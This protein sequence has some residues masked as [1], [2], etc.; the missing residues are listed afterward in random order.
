MMP[1]SSTILL[2]LLSI[3]IFL[4]T[5]H[6]S[7]SLNSDGVLLLSFK[8]SILNDPLKVLEGWD[9]N[10]ATPCLWR[11]VSCNSSSNSN[12]SSF[13]LTALDGGWGGGGDT[14]RVVGVSLPG[15]QLLGSLPADLGL[16]NHLQIFNLSSNSL[17]GSIP[18]SLFSLPDLRVLD[19]SNNLITGELLDSIGGLRSLEVLDVSENALAGNIPR[20]LGTLRNLSFVSLKGNYFSGSIPGGFN[21]VRF[22]DLSSNLLNGSLPVDLG[23]E[24]IQRFNLSFN[25]ISGDIS[26]IFGNK[27]PENATLDFSYNNITGEIPD[28]NV[29]VSQEKDSFAGN[30]DLCG[31]PSGNPCAIPSSP[32]SLPTATTSQPI[33]PPAFAAIPKSFATS[34]DGGPNQENP[35]P[36]K[37]HG[38]RPRIIAAIVVGDLTGIAI[39]AMVFLYACKRKNNSDDDDDTIIN[40]VKTLNNRS[41]ASAAGFRRDDIHK[42]SSTSRSSSSSSESKG[43][44]KWSCLRKVKNDDNNNDDDDDDTES[45]SECRSDDDRKSEQRQ[46]Q[47]GKLVTVDGGE[48]ELELETLLKA[49]AYI[50]GA[51]G[52]SITYKA[53]LEDGTVLAV[54]RVGESN[55]V[56]KMKD[57]EGHV[58]AVAKFVHPNLVK[59]RGFYWG[60]DEKLVIYEYVSN[61]SLAN[62]RYR[63]TGSSPCHIP[64]SV[65]LR[66]AK[67]IA[68]GLNYIHEKKNVHGNLKPNNVL[69]DADMEPKISDFGL[70]RLSMGKFSF[71]PGGSTRHF[72]SKRSTASRESFQ[73]YSVGA[74]P[75]PSGS[76]IGSVSPYHPPESLRSLKPNSKWDVY[77]FGVMLL[78]LLTGKVVIS[79]EYGPPVL[80]ELAVG[81]EDRTRM[82]R[83]AD[84]TIRGDLEGQEEALLSCLKLGYNCIS[85]VPQKRPSMKDALHVLEKITSTSPS[86]PPPPSSSSSSYY[87][88]P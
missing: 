11:G 46:Q 70:E 37:D 43:I 86:T 6:I 88:G 28:S 53:V 85:N 50:L 33:P 35:P 66:I 63:K 65:R 31:P 52:T 82:L 40:T 49:S 78:E 15:C 7:S 47:Q 61:G 45:E 42:S 55:S 79:D 22:M 9:Y 24:Q 72:G 23:G 76:S 41:P 71:I 13:N 62:A 59:V 27:I 3:I 20:N 16:L 34:P 74:T 18:D 84:P 67:G 83:M 2:L 1:T 25:R 17:N 69:L 44:S 19:V 68:R 60:S 8:Y 75:S 58:R 77:S 73:D 12:S 48:M 29:F 87:H 26:P 30:P 21:R 38:L 56:E 4:S 81:L 51:S 5:I 32:T 80:A 57:F 39:L 36:K 14:P 54:R 10:D 64:W